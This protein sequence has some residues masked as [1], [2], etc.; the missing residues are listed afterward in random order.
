MIGDE[1]GGSR[2]GKDSEAFA[3]WF[4]VHHDRVLAQ[5][6][7]TLRDR[8][9]AEDIAQETLL[10]AWLGRERMREEDLGAWLSVVARN[11]CISHIRRQK[12]QIP[13][14]VLPDT[15]DESAD[16]A[17]LAERAET[18]RAVRRA[19]R[20]V[21][22][23]H[24]KLLFL[25][26][27]EGVDYEEIREELGL[28]SAGTR[29]VL[30]RARRAMRDQLAAVGEGMAAFVAG[31]QIKVRLGST[32]VRRSMSSVETITGPSLQAGLNV[33]IAIGIS[34][35]GTGIASAPALATVV[36]PGRL[37]VVR[38]AR[39]SLSNPVADATQ[40]TSG[41]GTARTVGGPGASA[42][43]RPLHGVHASATIDPGNRRNQESVG[44]ASTGGYPEDGGHSIVRDDVLYPTLGRICDAKSEACHVNV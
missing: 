39:P 38:D 8:A 33:A 11:L 17:R 42:P 3:R 14:E 25:R 21:G 43:G 29:A 6:V 4:E 20:Q 31:L 5:C 32:R 9:A 23:R 27:I 13:T 44:P 15:P 16:P 24:R 35:S 37:A 2:A 18:R 41:S 28:S 40:T 36:R 26:E 1:R 22:E 19:M 30:F 7:R 10:R 34:L 12:K